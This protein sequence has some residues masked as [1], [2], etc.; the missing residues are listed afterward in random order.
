[1][2]FLNSSFGRFLLIGFITLLLLAP[3]VRVIVLIEERKERAEEIK[4]DIRIPRQSLASAVSNVLRDRILRGE[5]KAG[6]QLVQHTIATELGLSRIPVREALR[7]KLAR[8]HVSLSASYV[9]DAAEVPAAVDEAR[10]A[11]VAD[12]LKRLKKAH[13]LGGDVDVATVLRMPD[14]MRVVRDDDALEGGT[15][16]ELVAIVDAAI[17]NLQAM[18]ESEG[19]RLAAVVGNTDPSGSFKSWVQQQALTTDLRNGTGDVTQAAKVCVSFPNGPPV[20]IGDP[21]RVTVTAKYHW[22][23]F[24]GA[25]DFNIKSSSTM[26]LEQLPTYAAGCYPP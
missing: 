17:A 7:Q 3:L 8:G 11:Q 6:D 22:I 1:M 21:V 15:A 18:R 13:K 26:R 4:T 5:L 12:E 9:R 25:A 10:F 23:P 2:K 24:V 16:E 19:A 20:K 14:V